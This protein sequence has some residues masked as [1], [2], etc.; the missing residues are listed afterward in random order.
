MRYKIPEGTGEAGHGYVQWFVERSDGKET[1]LREDP[2]HVWGKCDL[3][4]EVCTC[5][6]QRATTQTKT[7]MVKELMS[8]LE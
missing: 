1:R 6:S 8:F 3:E 7:T 5:S 4:D 2:D